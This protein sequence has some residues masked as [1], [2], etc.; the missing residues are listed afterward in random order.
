MLRS[1]VVLTSVCAAYAAVLPRDALNGVH[2]AVDPKCG[3][4]GGRFGDVNIG[5]KSLTSY[6][7]IVAFGVRRPSLSSTMSCLWW[8]IG[9]MD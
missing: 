2:L 8:S 9:F 3:V 4:A 1:F 6:E 7:H 5:L